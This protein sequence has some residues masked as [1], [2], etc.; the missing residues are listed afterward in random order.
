MRN[1]TSHLISGQTL[2]DDAVCGEVNI[3]LSLAIS[4][5]TPLH[6]GKRC[7]K[8]S[9]AVYYLRFSRR[10]L[11]HFGSKLLPNTPRNSI[12]GL[13]ILLRGALVA[14]TQKVEEAP[15][16]VKQSNMHMREIE[17]LR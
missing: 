8:E 6:C 1:C 13:M 3:Q 14:R 2:I 4:W 7:V 9:A 17:S 12:K 11:K 16:G 15:L 5:K 10:A